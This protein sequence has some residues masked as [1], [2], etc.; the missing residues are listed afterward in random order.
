[1][2]SQVFPLASS[3]SSV[4]FDGCRIIHNSLHKMSTIRCMPLVISG[5]CTLHVN[6]SQREADEYTWLV[7]VFAASRPSLLLLQQ[8]LQLLP[9]PRQRR[10]P[11]AE[12][13]NGC[14]RRRRWLG[15][16]AAVALGAHCI[17]KTTRPFNSCSTG[18]DCWSNGGSSNRIIRGQTNGRGAC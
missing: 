18:C 8:L 7:I 10:C 15:C 11:P 14:L 16:L 2:V 1:M 13:R 12:R 6:V 9:L 3:A 17:R 5:R 4:Q